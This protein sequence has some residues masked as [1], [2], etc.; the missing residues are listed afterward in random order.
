MVEVGVYEKYKKWFVQILLAM[1]TVFTALLFITVRQ[2]QVARAIMQMAIGL[3][4][5]WVFIGGFLMYR[6]RD[7]IR[8]FVLKLP[9]H[10]KMKFILFVTL[11]ALIEEA[12]AV[13]MTNLAPFFGVQKGE[14]FITASTNYFD[15]VF[16]H[17]V[18][19]FIPLFIATASLLAQYQFSAFSMFIIF[20]IVGTVCEALYAGNVTMILAAY[21]WIFVYG[22]MVYL[23]VYTLPED[24]G[25][26]APHW[27]NYI[28]AP[29]R[30]F[31]WALP[32]LIPVVF[33]LVVIFDHPNIHF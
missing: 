15:V 5:C 9:G 22:L 2:D 13:L 8:N 24:R 30:I 6:F 10:W 7:R 11:L 18:I 33:T 31:I 1:L 17:S 4:V 3:I 28:F 25:A 19:I 26:K 12:I 14:A 29:I 23:P 32:I 20:G 16:F 21:Q 27:W